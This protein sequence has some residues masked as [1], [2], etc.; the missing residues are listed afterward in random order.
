VLYIVKLFI[1]FT[2]SMLVSLLPCCVCK[3]VTSC[4]LLRH[5]LCRQ[6]RQWRIVIV[7]IGDHMC[8]HVCASAWFVIVRLSVSLCAAGDGV[9]RQG[10]YVYCYNK[11]LFSTVIWGLVSCIFYLF[12]HRHHCILIECL[13]WKQT[14][15]AINKASSYNRTATNVWLICVHL[16]LF[17]YHFYSTTS[18]VQID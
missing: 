3:D 1:L 18:I 8:F 6:C 11:L 14:Q 12:F 5:V 2:V 4:L 16:L 10:M 17:G 7:D 15:I 9:G 13:D